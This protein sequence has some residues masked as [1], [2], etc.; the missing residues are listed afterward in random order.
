MISIVVRGGAAHLGGVA[1]RTWWLL[2]HCLNVL[3]RD[4]DNLGL[5]E[6]GE[7]GN[8]EAASLRVAHPQVVVEEV[9][10]CLRAPSGDLGAGLDG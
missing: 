5:V 9:D 3:R 4:V 2:V 8:N 10:D 7:D 1:W 6:A